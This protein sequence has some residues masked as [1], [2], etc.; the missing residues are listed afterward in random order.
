MRRVMSTIAAGLA[1]LGVA[2]A[3]GC[4][5]DVPG[6]AGT[7][8]AHEYPAPSIVWTIGTRRA[9]ITSDDLAGRTR[10]LLRERHYTGQGASVTAFPLR[11]GGVICQIRI[12]YP[13]GLEDVL[14]YALTPTLQPARC[15][16]PADPNVHGALELEVVWSAQ[17][18]RG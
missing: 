4:P 3:Q 7:G 17:D 2:T 9:Q 1:L 11:P 10:W 13:S 5:P 15:T 12:I 8:R 14:D 16:T 6:P 18:L